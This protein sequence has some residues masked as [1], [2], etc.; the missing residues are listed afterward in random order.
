MGQDRVEHSASA[1]QLE[2]KALVRPNYTQRANRRFP[3]VLV[4]FL[5]LNL[6]QVLKSGASGWA[7]LGAFL[8]SA[9]G[10][11]IAAAVVT[12][13]IAMFPSKPRQLS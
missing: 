3:F 2:G 10:A 13:L 5:F 12:L 9:Y 1:D 6:V 8:T 4:P 7:V 11:V